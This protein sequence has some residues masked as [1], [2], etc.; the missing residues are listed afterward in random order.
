MK[1]DLLIF[2]DKNKTQSK[3]FVDAE[4]GMSS[5]NIPFSSARR[6]RKQHE[7]YLL[8]IQIHFQKCYRYVF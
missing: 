8:D 7:K 4:P 1:V 2:T 5:D 6:S 3:I